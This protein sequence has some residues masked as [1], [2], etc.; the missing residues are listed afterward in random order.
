MNTSMMRILP[1]TLLAL[2]GCG[3]GGDDGDATQPTRAR[4]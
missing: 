4:T 1:F 2:I 3:G